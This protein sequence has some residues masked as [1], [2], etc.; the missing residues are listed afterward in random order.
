[1]TTVSVTTKNMAVKERLQVDLTALGYSVGNSTA[2]VAD[3]CIVDEENLERLPKDPRS[4]IIALVNAHSRNHLDGSLKIL[5][6]ADDILAIDYNVDEL[7]LRLRLAQLRHGSVEFAADVDSDENV[8]Q[9]NGIAINFETYEVWLDG[10]TIDLTFKE[11]ELLKCLMT[12]KG[13]VYSRNQ[14]LNDVWGYD[15]YGG[16]R[17]V[18]VHIRRLRSKLGRYESL[19]ETVRNVGYRFKR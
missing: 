5:L 14:L 4:V 7:A 10:K 12:H 16:A 15:Y 19:V 11:Y 6:D 13:R 9:E 1:M 18:D 2:E 8:L 17:T 3:I